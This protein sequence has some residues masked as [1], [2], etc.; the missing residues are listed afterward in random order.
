LDR[1]L[2][3]NVRSKI[4]HDRAVGHITVVELELNHGDVTNRPIL[5]SF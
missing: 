3:G 4:V 1:E 2:C 5:N